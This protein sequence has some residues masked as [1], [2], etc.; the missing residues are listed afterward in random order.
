MPGHDQAGGRVAVLHDRR[1]DPPER[2]AQV[3]GQRQHVAELVGWVDRGDRRARVSS[4]DAGVAVALSPSGVMAAIVAFLVRGAR[5]GTSQVG[6]GTGGLELDRAGPGRST[7]GKIRAPRVITLSAPILTPSPSTAPPVILVRV[8]DAPRRRRRCSRAARSRPRSG[9]RRAPR[10]ARPCCPAPTADVAA[11]HHQAADAGALGDARSRAPIS[12]RRDHA[13][14][15]AGRLVDRQPVLAEALADRRVRRCP[16]GCRR[17][18]AGS[19]PGVPM[20]SQ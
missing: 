1:L 20:S 5:R 9:R 7:P 14:V 8:A 19:A 13:A 12:G 15:H 18:P 10:R 17:C 11:E 2:V 3:L 16:R 6:I 4:A